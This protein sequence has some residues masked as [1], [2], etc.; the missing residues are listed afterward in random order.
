MNAIILKALTKLIV[1]GSSN[2]ELE[3]NGYFLDLTTTYNGL[4]TYTLYCEFY[5][6]DCRFVKRLV[7][8][9][10]TEI[11]LDLWAQDVELLIISVLKSQMENFKQALYHFEGK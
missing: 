5:I 10:N 6:G 7:D 11:D 1:D 8:N 4:N 9:L 2:Q 3:F